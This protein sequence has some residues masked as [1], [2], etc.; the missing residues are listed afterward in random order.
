MSDVR[1]Q[2]ESVLVC[3]DVRTEDNGKAILVGLY[4]GFIGLGHFPAK[5]K[6]RY[7]LVGKVQ[8][9]GNFRL[10]LRIAFKPEDESKE[11]PSTT[12]SIE[13]EITSRIDSPNEFQLATTGEPTF[14]FSGPG[15][16]VL[17]ARVNGEE[18]KDVLV[19][20][21]QSYPMVSNEQQQP[22]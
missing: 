11:H 3:D 5:M 19:K 21:I 7:W 18:F 15:H 22:S 2:I 10:D 16:L 17:A 8:G 12:L 20:P 9:F 6:L 13:G 1:L 14:D 4:T